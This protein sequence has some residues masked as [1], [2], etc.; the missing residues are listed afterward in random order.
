[1]PPALLVDAWKTRIVI[2]EKKP[3]VHIDDL[4]P[5]V[6]VCYDYVITARKLKVVG[7]AIKAARRRWGENGNTVAPGDP[8]GQGDQ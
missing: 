1:M 7:T 2:Y 8:G 4:L 3:G 5:R 6:M